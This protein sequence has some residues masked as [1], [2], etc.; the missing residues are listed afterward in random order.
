MTSKLKTMRPEIPG[1]KIT[2]LQAVRRRVVQAML[3][4]DRSRGGQIGPNSG[5]MDYLDYRK[6]SDLMDQISLYSGDILVNPRSS[7]DWYGQLE[8][9]CDQPL[10]FNLTMLVSR[11]DG[12]AM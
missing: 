9:I 2:T 1:G 3:R 11:L 6:P 10:P 8:I 12:G 5:A 7:S 4:L